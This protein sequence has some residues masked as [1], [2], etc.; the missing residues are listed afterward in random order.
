[1]AT[2]A[3]PGGKLDVYAREGKHI[4]MEWSTNEEGE[5]TADANTVWIICLHRKGSG[6]LPLGRSE[7]ETGGHKGY[8]LI[9]N[10]GFID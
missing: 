7:E 1:M 4:S 8:W 5:P 2:S 10:G 3:V 6:L 9:S